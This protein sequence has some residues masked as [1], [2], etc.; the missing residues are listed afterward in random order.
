MLGNLLHEI[1]YGLRLLVKNPGFAA[2][3]VLTIALG[4]G[5]NTAIFSVLY[6]V[7]WAPLPNPN[8]PRQSVLW[9][10]HGED[11]GFGVRGAFHVSPRE[12]LEWKKQSTSFEAFGAV[13]QT[14]VTLND[15]TNS[16]ERIQI[17]AH[18]P[19][20]ITQIQS[21]R[22]LLGRDFLPDEGIDGN[23]R[24]VVIS[25][26][27]W[28]RRYKADPNILG[29]KI[30]L[31]GVPHAIVGVLEPGSWDY[32]REPLWPALAIGPGQPD[33]DRH[34]L[35]V[36]GL[37][38]HGVTNERAQAE[39]DSI[40][41][42]IAE[43]Y[44]ATNKGWTVRVEASRNSWLNE[45]TRSNLGLL[46]GTV[47]LVLLIACVNV[48]NLLLARGGSR[49]KEVAVR[50]SLG[51]TE[52]RVFRQLLTESLILSLFGGVL[53]I[54]LSWLLLKVFLALLPPF[55]IP[56][57]TVVK[58]GL[59]PGVLVFTVG[60]TLAAGLIFGCAPA[61]QVARQSIGEALKQGSRSG[62]SQG[63]HR[64][65]QALVVAEF[66]L[67]LTLLAGAGLV[68]R[69]YWSRTHADFGIRT[70]NILTF[71]LPTRR[72]RFKSSDQVN[73]YNRV[74]VEKL[75]A[76][77]AV[78]RAAAINGLP[79]AST[80]SIGVSVASRPPA[81][82]ARP[83]Q[84]RFRMVGP[85][86]FEIFDVGTTAGR[87][88]DEQDRMGSMPVAM[89]NQTFV[90]EHL[91]GLDPLVQELVVTAG[92]E[93][94]RSRI[95]GVYHDIHNAEQFGGRTRPELIVP[96]A[97]FRQP[98]YAMAV[99]TAG[100]PAQVRNGIAAVIRTIDPEMPMANVRTIEQVVRE[101]TAFDRFEAALYGSFA[102]LAL[103]LAA[104]GIYGLMA[105]VV[106]QRTA[107]MGLR[108]ALGADRPT[109]LRLILRDGLKLALA[110][111]LFGA[112]GAYYAGQFLQSSL[113]GAGTVDPI[114]FAAVG[115]I[116]VGAAAIACFLPAH[117][118]AGIDPMSSLRTE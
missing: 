16:P 93:P 14:N 35:T 84:V 37:R 39:M 48:A 15:D 114:A 70:E 77:P 44:P 19:G 115:L 88:F 1:R 104:V 103:L 110:G 51:A 90:R 67:A 38:K 10:K 69:S 6:A 111:L 20:L 40:A 102:G 2:T 45:R 94:L 5:P 17:Q 41:R 97:Q 47:S 56:V 76:V 64:L 60:T 116:L 36:I 74:L 32:R 43:Q 54:A 57:A 18:T 9:S 29:Q 87:R 68:M 24:V 21:A 72:D 83:P 99:R 86:F 25:N 75:E 62:L 107:E 65:G 13:V 73:D 55:A 78:I 52:G 118:A 100:D 101:Q 7:F 22:M 28:Q 34:Y 63:R 85:G 82:P 27:L 112:G 11:K 71:E 92:R 105:F 50:I 8:V 26:Q 113:Y 96:M 4:I 89:V 117:R 98:Y 12:Y 31:D 95:V 61:W 106:S 3:A 66:A 33:Q 46:M 81:D 23:H 58:I 80:A 53:G 108:M 49:Q 79:L 30:R 42:N 91:D 109:I 59:S